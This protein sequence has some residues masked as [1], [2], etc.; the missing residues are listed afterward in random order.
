ML[1]TQRNLLRI[2]VMFACVAFC[3]GADVTAV[4]GGD[5]ALTVWETDDGLPH[6]SV[7]G[8]VQRP[9]GFL[10]ISTQGG[11]VRFDGVEFKRMRSPLLDGVRSASITGLMLEDRDSLL[12]ASQQSG[13]VRWRNGQFSLHPLAHRLAPRQKAVELFHEDDGVFWVLMGDRELWR[14]HGSDLERFAPPA[15]HNGWPVSFALDQNHHVFIARGNGI[16]AYRDGTL[17]RIDNS[18][19]SAVT[20]ASSPTGGIWIATGRR[21]SRFHDGQFTPYPAPWPA[22]MPPTRMFED[23]DGALW[24][25]AFEQG[26]LRWKNGETTAIATSHVTIAGISQ[27]NEGN[28]W[29]ATSG[30]GLNRLQPTRL[31]LVASEPKW[32]DT[33]SGTVCEDTRGNIWFANRKGVRRIG[34]A[35]V[36]VMNTVG[37]WPKRAMPVTADA[38]GNIW[39]AVGSDLYRGRADS[40]EA[41]VLVAASDQ[42]TVHV[43]FVARDGSVWVGRNNGPLFR[44]QPDGTTQSFGAAE[45]F[46]SQRVRCI[47]QDVANAIW[48]GTE[49]GELFELVG[50]RFV[51]QSA[52][53]SLPGHSVRAIYGDPDGN[54]WIG[55]GGGGIVLRHNAQFYRLGEAQGLPDEVIS[56]IVADDYGWL[57]FGSRRGIFKVQRTDLLACATGK[58]ATVTPT[59][60][61]RADGL[62]GISAVGSY[63]PTAW[64]THDGRIWFVTRKGLVR[65]QPAQHETDRRQPRVYVEE[66]RAD[67]RIIDP[68]H[69]HLT[70]AV[71]K[72]EFHFTA[73]TFVAPERVRFR[74]RLDGFD[75]DWVDGGTQR[76][77]SYPT[78]PA[79]RY[80]FTV[81]ASAGDLAW[82]PATAHV[83]FTVLPMWWETW[84]ARTAAV[85]AVLVVL[86]AL[87]RFWSHRRL[88]ARLAR[89]EQERRL[90]H[91]R[92]RIAR[93]LHD[94]LG[95]SLTQ[96]SMMADEL[97]EDWPDLPA[98]QVRSAQLADRVRTIARDL[99]AVVWTVSPNNDQL[100]SLAA[101]LC[102]Y[103]EEYFRHSSI[104]CRAR[105]A[106]DIPALPLSPEVRHHLFLI[107]KEL[108]NNALKHSHAR[109]IDV[110]MQMAAGR[111]ELIVADDG[112]G[113]SLA[114][115]EQS[116]RNGLK[117]LRARA[118]EAGAVLNLAST[119]EGTVATL[120]FRTAAAPLPPNAG[121][122]A[123]PAAQPGPVTPNGALAPEWDS[124]PHS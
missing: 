46:T 87:V 49:D 53:G 25:A 75:N 99:D 111:F 15:A 122:P 119:P 41:P 88:R 58:I 65:T 11:L 31:S 85:G 9:D 7:S 56:Q 28:L 10:W 72:L 71:R 45:G 82:S 52:Q 6:N 66:I 4:A 33:V 42:G 67:G 59:S 43:I 97:A 13:L 1:V 32:V 16:E 60:F 104:E 39:L 30:G 109:H 114:A 3:R 61:G 103:A 62:S 24:M 115:A 20:I 68:A 37:G 26:L 124:S 14:C 8:I 76:F 90:E 23:R 47:S 108:F 48:V 86:I 73:P 38:S 54:L 102:H 112:R 18:P 93:N 2:V 106:D 84:W 19:T 110:T 81:A 101:Y 35:S 17:Q 78:L 105:V 55:T 121:G 96:A 40:T 98:P 5:F 91:E 123:A 95:A 92:V 107:A 100:S 79:G 51:L 57:W 120:Q 63:Q 36:D 70:S 44:H 118:A 77:A 27:D 50:D 117:N 64:K 116:Q 80:G 29:I 113:F 34:P 89:L 21:L 74:Y 94:D 12:I 83:A 22:S 69:E